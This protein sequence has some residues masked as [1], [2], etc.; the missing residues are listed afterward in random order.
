MHSISRRCLAVTT[1]TTGFI[2]PGNF[3]LD[4][5]H[6]FLEGGLNLFHIYWGTIVLGNK[7]GSRTAVNGNGLAPFHE[8]CQSCAARSA[9]WV[10]NQIPGLGIVP[11][12]L[13]DRI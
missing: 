1:V 5:V 9:H 2:Q 13:A 11:D 10:Q 7:G 6:E 4:L 12:I 8:C 3:R